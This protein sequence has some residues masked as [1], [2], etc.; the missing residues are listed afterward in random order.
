VPSAAALE[1]IEDFNRAVLAGTHPPGPPRQRHRFALE[2]APFRAVLVNAG[3]TFTAGGIDV[4]PSMRVLRRSLSASTSAKV[5]ADADEYTWGYV[6]GL[7][8]VGADVG[9]IQSGGYIGG[10]AAA[11]VTGRTAGLTVAETAM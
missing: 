5:I 7:C 11:L 9:G 8:A 1:T 2:Q 3:I 4:D 10:L 6:D